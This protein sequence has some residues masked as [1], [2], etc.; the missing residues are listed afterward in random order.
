MAKRLA[1]GEPMSSRIA[2]AA[3]KVLHDPRTSKAAKIAAGSALAQRPV[4]SK[5]R[6]GK[7]SSHAGLKDGPM[8]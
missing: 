8:R 1:D 5:A 3:S 6:G 4:Q 2:S 7:P